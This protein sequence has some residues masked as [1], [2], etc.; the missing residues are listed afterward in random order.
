MTKIIKITTY[1]FAI[2]GFVLTAGFFAVKFGL[3]NTTGIIDNQT[4]GFLYGQKDEKYTAKDFTW[5]QG[6][7]WQ[8]F[9][10]AVINDL[11]TL[12]RVEGETGIKSRT[13]V[14]ILLVEQLRLFYSERQTFKNVFAPLKILGTQSQFSWGV[15]GIKPDTAKK[16]EQNLKDKNSIYYLGKDFENYLNFSTDNIDSERFTRITDYKDRYY[17]Y[18]YSA[19][20]IKEIAQSWNKSGFPIDYDIGILATLF[21]IGFEN[22]NPN[23]EPK[24][25]GAEIEIN[26]RTYSFGGLAKEFYYSDEL[27]EYFPR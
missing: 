24:I 5:N 14:S 21:N 10:S 1:I 11:A 25:G 22:S 8:T 18:L 19:I 26:G 6:E 20:Y 12:K 23:P 4:A 17:S 15:T 7:E 27:L 13:I 16:I 3:T 9:K 2:I